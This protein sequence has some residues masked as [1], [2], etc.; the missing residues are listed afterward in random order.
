MLHGPADAVRHI[1]Q[2]GERSEPEGGGEKDVGEAEAAAQV[3][4]L[5]SI[6]QIA[7]YADFALEALG[8]GPAEGC[9]VGP[10]V[11]A[12]ADQ[13]EQVVALIAGGREAFGFRGLG[14]G[15]DGIGPGGAEGGRVLNGLG[16]AGLGLLL[17]IVAGAMVEL[18]AG[19]EQGLGQGV[20][21]GGGTDQA[22]GFEQGSRAP[23]GG[24]Q[25][26]PGR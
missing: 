14:E 16:A 8:G 4:L 13:K 3:A 26:R 11:V 5:G 23:D 15:A 19:A 18:L 12:V 25:R 6:D 1:D 21:F 9:G 17:E 22:G 2:Q 7:G 20:Y 24:G 10:D